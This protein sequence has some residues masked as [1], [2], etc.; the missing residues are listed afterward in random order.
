MIEPTISVFFDDPEG[1]AQWLE[2]HPDGWLLNAG[3]SY[4]P[5]I[6][7]ATCDH[8]H[9]GSTSPEKNLAANPK[10]C[11]RDC[12]ALVAW[13]AIMGDHLESS[14]SPRAV[15]HA[16]RRATTHRGVGRGLGMGRDPGRDGRGGMR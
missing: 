15:P 16:P 13:A 12:D 14:L 2:A 4:G 5:M 7:H 11:A 3:T 10:H 6:H 8:I 1:Y 9:P